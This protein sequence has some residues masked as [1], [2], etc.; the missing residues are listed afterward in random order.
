MHFLEQIAEWRPSIADMPM[1][2]IQG[3]IKRTES[4]RQFHVALFYQIQPGGNVL[5]AS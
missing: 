3:S 4:C 5:L 1:E 2:P